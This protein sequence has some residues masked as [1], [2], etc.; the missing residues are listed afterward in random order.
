[1]R[2]F[3]SRPIKPSSEGFL[4]QASGTEPP[5]PAAFRWEDRTLVVASVRRTWRTSK[6]D[7]GDDYLKRHWFELQTE[8]GSI[9]EVYYDREAR[10][11]AARWWLYTIDE[12][13]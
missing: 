7:R 2:R 5:V 12:R 8:D 4:T 9:V 11:G 3:V 13:D 6:N 10:R 1:M